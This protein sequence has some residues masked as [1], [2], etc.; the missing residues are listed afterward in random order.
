M[1]TPLPLAR[2]VSREFLLHH[3]VC[4]IGFGADGRLRV[5]TDEGSQLEAL[6]DLG[7]AYGCAVEAETLPTDELERLIE[8]LATH[9]ER[10]IELESGAGEDEEATT[11][12]R[13]LANQPPVIRYVNLLV[14]DAF[15]AG[16]SDIHLESTR[17][18]LSVRFRLDGVLTPASEP[19]AQLQHAIVSRIKILADLD[20]AERR[21][22]QDGRIRVRLQERELDL[23]ISTVPTMFGESL[24]LRLLDRGGRP[25]RLEELGLA[26]ELE[27][28]VAGL[29]RRPHGMVLVTG[30]TGSGK[31]TTLYAALSLRDA[32]AEKIVTVEDPVEYQL[33]GITQV[34]IHGQAGVTFASALR[35]L[36]RQ[37]P[38]VVMVGEMRDPETTAMAI[39]AAMTGHLVFSTL[40][41][42]DA[43]GALP[44]LLDLGTP[45]YLVAATLEGVLAQRL[46]RRICDHCREEYEPSEAGVARLRESATG[47]PPTSYMRGV[48]CS[49]CRGT[50]YRKRIGLFELAVFTD[51][52][53]AAVARRVTGDELAVLARRSGMQT[54]RADGW[55]KVRTGET[56]VEE[57]LRV[58]QH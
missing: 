2:G 57:V 37:D 18:G 8:R 35:S 13:D 46:V 31:T 41:T 49:A 4:P 33:S 19:S 20:I 5:A 23:R 17:N 22:P 40:H 56:T 53:K 15:D 47:D 28:A 48:G 38:D 54:L 58:L 43:L 39:Q 51:A 10:A 12:V 7:I 52:M 29:A 25:V 11:D 27:S 16:A 9:T 21:R 55:A 42:N 45:E 50:G 3:R 26:A 44:R 34:P 1:T 32:T 6:D 36:L 14:R 24:V 30:P